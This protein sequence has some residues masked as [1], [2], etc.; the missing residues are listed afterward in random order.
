MACTILIL[1]YTPGAVIIIEAPIVVRDSK[2]LLKPYNNFR[3]TW[4]GAYPKQVRFRVQ[5]C[6]GLEATLTLVFSPQSV[7]RL[8]ASRIASK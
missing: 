7:V 4:G 6:T 8:W 3:R 5:D 2:K 1:Q